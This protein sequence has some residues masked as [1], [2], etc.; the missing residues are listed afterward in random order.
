MYN[1]KY[2]CRYHKD[3][4]FLETDDVNDEEKDFIR[5]ILYKED[6]INI[7]SIDLNENT[8]VFEIVIL[9]LYNKIKDC[10]QLKNCMKKMA[11]MFMS[12]DEEIGL[13][14]LYSYDYMHITHKCVSEY[15]ESG[16][17]SKENIELLDKISK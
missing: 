9:E 8:N 1:T 12:E 17:I 5:D 7:F 16:L 10:S 13:T 14:I 11:N 3:D 6:V 2:E 4:V 15:L